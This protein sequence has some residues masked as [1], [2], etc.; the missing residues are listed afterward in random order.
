[1]Q[2]WRAGSASEYTRTRPVT[3]D[4]TSMRAI[5][6]RRSPRIL[7]RC[8]GPAHAGRASGGGLMMFPMSLSAQDRRSL[9]AVGCFL[10]PAH[11]D[12]AGSGSAP[13]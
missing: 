5:C 2:R 10:R 9:A 7:R 11:A 1:V 13:R 6:P 8:W 12:P 3:A 4:L